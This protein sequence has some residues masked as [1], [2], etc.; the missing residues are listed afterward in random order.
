VHSATQPEFS[1]L[2]ALMTNVLAKGYGPRWAVGSDM[3]A[4]D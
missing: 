4:S 3:D 2:T 1:S